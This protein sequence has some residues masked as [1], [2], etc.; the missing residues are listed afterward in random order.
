M[1]FTAENSAQSAH[2]GS[3]DA[4]MGGADDQALRRS[5]TLADVGLKLRGNA[6]ESDGA[7]RVENK[8]G[9]IKIVRAGDVTALR[10]RT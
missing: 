9:R 4:D 7:L 3:R 1:I 2:V 5:F 6:L 8:D 10:P